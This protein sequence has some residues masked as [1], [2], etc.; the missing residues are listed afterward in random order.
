MTM[1]YWLVKSEPEVWSWDDQVKAKVTPWDGVKNAQALNNMKAMKKGDQVFFYHSNTDR[2]IVGVA[3]V[4]KTFY[5][6]PKD[7]KSGLVDLKAV[8][9]VKTPVPLAQ[10]KADER[11][12]H[13][14]LVRQSRLSVMPIDAAS[15]KI[16]SKMAGI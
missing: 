5:P 6:D 8:K 1:A 16:L 10:V 11:L 4:V 13:L 14:A 15:W 2:Q 3:E 12:A 9:P 7:P